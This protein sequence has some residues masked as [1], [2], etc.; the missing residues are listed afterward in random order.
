MPTVAPLS[1]TEDQGAGGGD[2]SGIASGSFSWTSVRHEKQSK[3]SDHGWRTSINAPII[4]RP[5]Q[6]TDGRGSPDR[7]SL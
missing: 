3:P 2:W 5:G 7:G 1:G 6:E 4:L